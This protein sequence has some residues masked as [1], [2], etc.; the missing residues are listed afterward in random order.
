MA[1]SEEEPKY[2]LDSDQELKRLASNHAVVKDAMG[3][4]ILAPV[5]FS[6]GRLEVLDSCTADGKETLLE[7]RRKS[8]FS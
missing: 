5:D 4:L 3:R 8:K 6:A 1:E 2:F 7:C